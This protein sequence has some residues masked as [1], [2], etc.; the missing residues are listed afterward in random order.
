[1][2][3]R[4]FDIKRFAIN[5]GP[6]IRTTI[7]MKGCPLHCVWCHNP[8]GISSQPQMMFTRK[9]CIGC[10]SC[11]GLTDEEAAEVCPT[12]A[13]QMAGKQWTMDQLMAVIEKERKVME[14]S[15]HGGVT[16]CG[17]EPLLHHADTLE[18]LRELGK[19][20]FHRCIDTSLYAPQHVVD[21]V[22]AECE[23]LLIDI[24][25]MNS[26]IHLKH[27]GVPNPLI[28]ANIRHLAEA[29]KP[30]WIRIPLIEGINADEDNIEQTASFLASLPTPPQQVNLLPYHDTGKGKHD[31]LGTVYNP[32]N[33][34]MATPSESTLQRCVSQFAMHGIK[35][36][37]GG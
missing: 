26:D 34:A 17:G 6:G 2:S 22:A 32:A 20:G 14:D 13:R 29:H 3:F 1:M 12:L 25:H 9:K 31:R 19:R 4:L 7:F 18:I 21:A 37:T 33:I 16:I 28:L 10:K 15:H 36:I 8:E 30:F 27:T 24:K 5:D 11:M 23:L 35:A